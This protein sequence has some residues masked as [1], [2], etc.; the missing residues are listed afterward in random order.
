MTTKHYERP[1]TTYTGEAG[2]N[3]RTKYQDDSATVPR[4]PIASS[5][6]DGDINYLVDAV[7]ELYDTAVSGTLPD[8]SVTLAKLSHLSAGS[9][10]YMDGTGTPT[11]L[12]AGASGQ[13]LQMGAAVPAWTDVPRAVP[14][15]V[16][17]PYVA[18]AAPTGWLLCD[19]AAVSRSTYADLFAACGTAYGS[20]DGSTTF[21]LPDL[22][23]RL[24]LGRD[25]M[26][27]TSANRV[28]ATEADTLGGASGEESFTGTTDDHTLTID[29]IPAHTHSLPA[30]VGKDTDGKA[31]TDG[32]QQGGSSNTGSV[33]GGQAHS[34]GLTDFNLMSPYLTLSYIIKT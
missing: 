7:N 4:V 3:N 23:G 33:G 22:R 34:H 26:G 24:P 17:M 16:L 10:Y 8:N 31:G 21:N 14:A 18:N 13:T 9:M 27:G 29:E 30:N 5:K 20:G 32:L 1:S 28:T 11:E 12:E 19:G 25:N 2:L 6:V 15:G